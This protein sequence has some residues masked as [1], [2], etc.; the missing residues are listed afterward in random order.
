MNA[1]VTKQHTKAIAAQEPTTVHKKDSMNRRNL[2]TLLIT[3][4]MALAFSTNALGAEADIGPVSIQSLAIV[5]TATG[6][7][8][9]GNMEI[10]ILHNFV[11]PQGFTC[12]DS[13]YLTTRKT[14]DPIGLCSICC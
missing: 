6:G 5:G 4:V 12:T 13:H 2:W 7:H 1:Q 3:T 14:T 9:A 8:M 11:I 10:G